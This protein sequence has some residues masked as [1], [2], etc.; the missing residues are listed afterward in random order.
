MNVFY[1]IFFKSSSDIEEC[2]SWLNWDQFYLPNNNNSKG[3]SSQQR[4]YLRSIVPCLA[5]LKWPP[6]PTVGKTPSEK[7]R[8]ILFLANS[9]VNFALSSIRLNP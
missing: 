6:I 5:P 2:H 1:Y 3:V 4:S 9:V 7:S 8:V